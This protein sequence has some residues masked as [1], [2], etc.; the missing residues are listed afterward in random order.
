MASKLLPSVLLLVA[1]LAVTAVMAAE[2]PIVQAAKDSFAAIA[3][4]VMATWLSLPWR[5]A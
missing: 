1:M 5:S 3:A 4:R 2:A